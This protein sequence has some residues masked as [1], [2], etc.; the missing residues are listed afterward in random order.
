MNEIPA[1]TPLKSYGSLD[2]LNEPELNGMNYQL[3]K[4]NDSI[5]KKLNFEESFA[6]SEKRKA[7]RVPFQ[8]LDQTNRV[9]KSKSNCVESLCKSRK[10]LS[11]SPKTQ[12]RKKRSKNKKTSQKLQSRKKNKLKLSIVKNAQTTSGARRCFLERLPPLFRA[13]GK[14]KIFR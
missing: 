10:R 13:C 3:L 7:T 4:K 12:R 2:L 9:L 6:S 8:S 1:F 14:L 5:V 11:K